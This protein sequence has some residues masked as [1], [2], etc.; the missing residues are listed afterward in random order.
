MSGLF[1]DLVNAARKSTFYTNFPSLPLVSRVQFW[2]LVDKDEHG[3]VS[4]AVYRALM[5]RV[6]RALAPQLAAEE[7]EKIVAVRLV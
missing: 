1:L 6:S 7:R 2:N 5:L 4:R 3:L